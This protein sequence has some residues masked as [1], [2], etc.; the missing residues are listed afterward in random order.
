M[1]P[2][3]LF[4]SVRFLCLPYLFEPAEAALALIW[5]WVLSGCC[6]TW[7]EESSLNW[8]TTCWRS[9]A[10]VER[11]VQ[12]FAVSSAAADDCSL[13]LEICV[14]LALICSVV[15]DCSVAAVAI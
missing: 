10:R 11:S 5:V 15:A 13:A 4:S 8:L 2:V 14:T 12:A 1:V 3:L 7:G 9:N 6:E